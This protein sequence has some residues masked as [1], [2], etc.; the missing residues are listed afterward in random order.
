MG[1]FKHYIAPLLALVALALWFF[2][3]QPRM[4]GDEPPA[5]N[6]SQTGQSAESGAT[7]PDSAK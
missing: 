1:D 6:P 7:E 2:V 5:A 4:L 3:I